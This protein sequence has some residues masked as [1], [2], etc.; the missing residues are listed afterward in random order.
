[1]V[2][3]KKLKNK[4]TSASDLAKKAEAMKGGGFKKDE[5]IWSPVRDSN[6]NF[7][8]IIRFLDISPGDVEIEEKTDVQVD[9]FVLM[10]KHAFKGPGGWYK[11]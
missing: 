3:F 11:H 8:G 6:G 5:R 2:D 9:P 1:M 4:R 7:Q 10:F